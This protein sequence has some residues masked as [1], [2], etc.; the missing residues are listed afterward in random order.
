M[1]KVQIGLLLLITCLSACAS[2]RDAEL[3]K[4]EAYVAE[5]DQ[6]TA[7]GEI[8]E[9]EADNLKMHAYQDYQAKR[10]AEEKQLLRDSDS[11]LLKSQNQELN[12]VLRR[13]Q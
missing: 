2:M 8:A 3:L 6:R 12:A 7:R 13:A 10:K 4:Y 5:V 11:Q 9:V 1:A